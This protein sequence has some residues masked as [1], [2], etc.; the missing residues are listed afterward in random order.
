MKKNIKLLI[1]IVLLICLIVCIL[2]TKYFINN[3]KLNECE[4]FKLE[5]IVLDVNM[6]TDN[7][8]LISNDNTMSLYIPMIFSE[9]TD[10]IFASIE[11]SKDD[12]FLIAKDLNENEFFELE[13][14]VEIKKDNDNQVK[15]N[16][17][18][19]Y[20]YV[21]GSD[22]YESTIEG[23]IRSYIYCEKGA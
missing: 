7:N 8:F 5:D 9:N 20:T 16:K 1:I 11:N 10:Y 4:D 12:Y 13:S 23:I 21:I 14:F 3:T 17:Y 15:I 18:N 22:D 19:E 6:A 2:L